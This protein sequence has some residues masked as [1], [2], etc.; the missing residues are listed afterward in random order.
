MAGDPTASTIWY[1]LAIILVGSALIGRRLPMG[2]VMRMA[3]LWVAIFVLLLGGF[4]VA[5]RQGWLTGRFAENGGVAAP[6][7]MPGNVPAAKPEGQ[8]LHIPVAEDGHYWVEGR[9]NG[10]A[11][12]FLIDSGATVTALS[13]QTARAAGLNFEMGE[14]G[15]ILN[16]ANGRIEAQRSSISTLSVGPI[17]ASDLPVLISP[18]FGEVNVV[19]MNFLSRLKSWGVQNGEMV[20]TP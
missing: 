4:K 2:S 19:G 13:E 7:D 1:V 17:N 12:R 6:N 20:L 9:I 3:V 15:V 18:A 11:A 10:T 14:P 16:T 8:A 5:Q